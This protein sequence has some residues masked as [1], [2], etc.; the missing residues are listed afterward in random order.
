MLTWWYVQGEERG[1]AAAEESH[2]DG[3]GV[4]FFL[5]DCRQVVSYGIPAHDFAIAMISPASSRLGRV[6][7]LYCVWIS[8]HDSGPSPTRE[9]AKDRFAIAR[10]GTRIL[11]YSLLVLWGRGEVLYVVGCLEW[12]L[13]LEL[14]NIN[15]PTTPRPESS[16]PP[17]LPIN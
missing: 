4:V 5:F 2:L 1:E 8:I 6:S 14:V 12:K 13:K 15:H 11:T 16:N 7:L 9:V 17:S 3:E 10:P